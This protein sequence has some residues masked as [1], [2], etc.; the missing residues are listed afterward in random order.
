[1]FFGSQAA[2]PW[3][4]HPFISSCSPDDVYSHS[5]SSPPRAMGV[6][7]E[8]ITLTGPILVSYARLFYHTDLTP[9]LSISMY[10]FFKVL[11]IFE[12]KKGSPGKW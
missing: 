11:K 12:E 8:H 2:I 6:T 10:S 7:T 3:G 9:L 5:Y 1:M 4:N